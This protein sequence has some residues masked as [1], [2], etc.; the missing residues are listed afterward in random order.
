MFF[1]LG[2]IEAAS[3][4]E[5]LQSAHDHQTLKE[6]WESSTPKDFP[7]ELVEA[8]DPGTLLHLLK[9]VSKPR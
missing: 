9:Y 3:L 5:N 1:H 2:E 8:D 7:V 6:Y 4:E